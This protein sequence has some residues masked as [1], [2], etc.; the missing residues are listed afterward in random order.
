MQAAHSNDDDLDQSKADLE[1]R[2]KRLLDEVTALHDAMKR[3]TNRERS[4]SDVLRDHPNLAPYLFSGRNMRKMR[5]PGADLRGIDFQGSDL[6][7]CDIT[8]ARIAGANF[9]LCKASRA[10]MRRAADWASHVAQHKWRMPRLPFTQSPGER[11]SLA[12]YLPELVLLSSNMLANCRALDG[13]PFALTD[14]EEKAL[15]DG[16]LAIALRP[17]STMEWRAVVLRDRALAEQ[18][19]RMA[20]REART[21]FDKLEELLDETGTPSLETE[22]T[23]GFVGADFA[24]TG[25]V[26]LLDACRLLETGAAGYADRDVEPEMNTDCTV[27]DLWISRPRNGNA[28][29][30]FAVTSDKSVIGTAFSNIARYRRG[31]REPLH[32]EAAYLRP[33]FFLRYPE[34]QT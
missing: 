9:D 27:S 18:P 11:F 28:R 33:I 8:N 2:R 17:L 24:S 20:V 4:F 19:R 13:A 14:A 10:G 26:A 12:P 34:Q 1:A 16:R 29:P 21:Y 6:S 25:L 30:E 23:P 7:G 31:Q 15:R 5:L 32:G 3:Q 22:D